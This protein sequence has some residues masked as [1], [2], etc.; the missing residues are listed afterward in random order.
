MSRSG[1]LYD[2]YDQ[3]PSDWN[4]E[5]LSPAAEAFRYFILERGAAVWTSL[6]RL[7]GRR[8]PARFELPSMA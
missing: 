4:R 2:K 8:L 6:A 3:K 5:T 7:I 1:I